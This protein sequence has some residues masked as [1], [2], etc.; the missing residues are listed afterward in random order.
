MIIDKVVFVLPVLEEQLCL[1]RQFMKE[2][3]TLLQIPVHINTLIPN[4]PIPQL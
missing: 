2:L 3:A 1:F 4:I